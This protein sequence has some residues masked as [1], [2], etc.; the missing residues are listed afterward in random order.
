MRKIPDRFRLIVLWVLNRIGKLE[1]LIRRA[2]VTE[3]GLTGNVSVVDRAIAEKERLKP[4]NRFEMWLLGPVIQ[5]EKKIRQEAFRRAVI[6]VLGEY[7][8]EW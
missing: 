8:E 5:F 4:L 3:V 7:P 6:D 2:M 1:P